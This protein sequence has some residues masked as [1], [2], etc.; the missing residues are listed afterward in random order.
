[1]QTNVLESLL[2]TL[3]TLE[4]SP[5]LSRQVL[6]FGR[7]AIEYWE[8]LS[9]VETK[10]LSDGRAESRLSGLASNKDFTTKIRTVTC[11]FPTLLMNFAKGDELVASI[12]FSPLKYHFQRL[13]ECDHAA[14]A[15]GQKSRAFACQMVALDLLRAAVECWM[16]F[17]SQIIRRSEERASDLDN[18]SRSY[19]ILAFKLLSKVARNLELAIRYTLQVAFVSLDDKDIEV[20]PKLQAIELEINAKIQSLK[21]KVDDF[22]A[23]LESISDVKRILVEE[24]QALNVTRLTI[25]AAIFLPLSL[26]SSLLSMNNRA[27]DLGLLWYDYVGVCTMLI[28]C[29]F[30][31]YQYMRIKD[32]LKVTQATATAK[33]LD[34]LKK[35]SP[36]IWSLLKR[37]VKYVSTS[38]FSSKVEEWIWST[39]MNLLF[40][41]FA[42]TIVAS[43]WVGMFKDVGLGLRI[44]GFGTAGWVGV[45]IVL[46]LVRSCVLL[47]AR[48]L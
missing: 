40:T 8:S 47:P 15:I 38:I 1:M 30:I 22:L 19:D 27:A 10:L 13:L 5:Y 46:L 6:F 41:A 37:L 17:L 21:N 28:F 11:K 48:R 33:T 43:F 45:L 44:M 42:A 29:V 16:V 7:Y 25:L 20:K 39:L 23:S 24:D 32:I 31:V 36:Y 26:F 2:R 3:D 18:R 12:E 34:W 35:K 4:E 9:S 14:T